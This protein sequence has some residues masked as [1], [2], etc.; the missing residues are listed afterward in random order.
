MLTGYIL[1]AFASSSGAIM[2]TT[3]LKSGGS[4]LGIDERGGLEFLLAGRRRWGTTALCVLHYY[5][6]Q[7]PRAEQVPVPHDQAHALGTAGTLSMSARGVLDVR[8]LDL[9]EEDFDG[10]PA[11][12]FRVR[13]TT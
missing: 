10:I 13:G 6:R 7:H 12:E 8:Q 5:D 9:S 3:T 4:S 2:K 1:A 11:G